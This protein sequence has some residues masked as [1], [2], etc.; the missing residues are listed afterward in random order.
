M[1][2]KNEAPFDDPR[3]LFGDGPPHWLVN[4]GKPYE[5]PSQTLAQANQ[6]RAEVINNLRWHGKRHGD[7]AI[8]GLA[9][10][11]LACK[12]VKPCL[13][14]ACPICMRAQQRWLVLACINAVRQFDNAE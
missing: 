7:D 1:P 14:G 9:E 3:G 4:R 8:I 11:L 5:R 12:P 13:S 10:K 2:R 6:Q